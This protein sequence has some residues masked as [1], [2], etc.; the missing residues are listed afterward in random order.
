MVSYVCDDV[1][2]ECERKHVGVQTG[3]GELSSLG[4]ALGLLEN[5][6]ER[7]QGVLDLDDRGVVDGVSHCGGCLG[8]GF[9]FVVEGGLS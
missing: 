4:G 2:L 6:L 1:N 3:L 7:L 5:G 8:R 9:G